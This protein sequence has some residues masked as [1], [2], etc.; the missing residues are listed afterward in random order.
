MRDRPSTPSSYT[1][2]LPLVPG[3]HSAAGLTVREHR[4]TLG[5]QVSRGRRWIDRPSGGKGPSRPHWRWT[6]PHPGFARDGLDRL[7]GLSL[8][9]GLQP[10][11]G[12]GA[13][14][15]K[16]DPIRQDIAMRVARGTM[17]G[18][19]HGLHDG[20]GSHDHRDAEGMVASS[21]SVAL[22]LVFLVGRAIHGPSWDEAP[23]G[24][25]A[26]AD[27]GESWPH[28]TWAGYGS[29][30]GRVGYSWS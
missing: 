17:Q 4:T 20:I 5:L 27:S 15:F 29:H 18:Y 23:R 7:A 19:S 8:R 28:G 10:P 13:V 3:P 16:H 25:P 24:A 12:M 21:A 26:Y 1:F 6:S 2:M 9:L 22:C 14:G 30:H 11:E